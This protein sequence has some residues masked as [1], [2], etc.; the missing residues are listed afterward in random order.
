MRERIA[1]YLGADATQAGNQALQTLREAFLHNLAVEL[2][3]H[4]VPNQPAGL[5]HEVV[6]RH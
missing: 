5:I 3:Y 2:W 6:L 1:V 4:P